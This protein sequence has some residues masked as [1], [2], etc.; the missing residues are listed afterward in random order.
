LSIYAIFSS[1][2]ATL[3]ELWRQAVSVSIRSRIN[4]VLYEIHRNI[5][6]DLSAQHLAK[7]AALS[8]QHFH[9]VFKTCV[10]EPVHHYIRR[11]RLEQAANQLM[12]DHTGSILSV[13]LKCGFQSLS[14]FSQAFKAQHGTPPGQWRKQHLEPLNPDFLRDPIIAAGY[15]VIK[16]RSLPRPDIVDISPVSVVSVRHR[17]YNAAIRESWQKLLAW[18]AVQGCRENVQY[19]LYHSNPAC[20]PLE[21]C[22]YVACLA[23]EKPLL[24]RTLVNTLKIPGGLHARFSLQGRYGEFVPYMSRILTEWAPASGYTMSTTP[25]WTRYRKNQF[26]DADNEFDADLYIP[27]RIEV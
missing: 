27:L 1:Y 25:A 13:A 21:E 5:A 15:N 2:Q 10:G 19:A 9:R 7:V 6:A 24:K 3:Y 16:T 14:S 20:V 23:Y 17:G 18:A 11:V 12:F 4:D 26:I 22:R 8:E